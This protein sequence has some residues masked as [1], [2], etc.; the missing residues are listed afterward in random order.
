MFIT[1]H[2]ALFWYATKGNDH[3]KLIKAKAHKKAYFV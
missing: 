2:K 1:K 3:N